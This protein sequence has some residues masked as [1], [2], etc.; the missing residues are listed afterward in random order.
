MFFTF[1]IHA[2]VLLLRSY[3]VVSSFQNLIFSLFI[4]LIGEDRAVDG[5]GK[6]VRLESDMGVATS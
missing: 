6:K 4:T 2:P 1:I 5:T 3:T